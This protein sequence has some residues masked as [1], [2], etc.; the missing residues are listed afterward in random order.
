MLFKRKMQPFYYR[1]HQQRETQ[2]WGGWRGSHSRYTG[3]TA[4]SRKNRG[5]CR[6]Y[7]HTSPLTSQISDLK[8]RCNKTGDKHFCSATFLFLTYQQK[9]KEMAVAESFFSNEGTEVTSYNSSQPSSFFMLGVGGRDNYYIFWDH[10]AANWLFC[11]KGLKCNVKENC[12]KNETRKSIQLGAGDSS[13]CLTV[14]HG[15]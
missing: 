10:K 7:T 2:T 11:W 15:F 3:N 5:S 14:Q 13:L 9:L 12:W 1:N 6:T 8:Q 4:N